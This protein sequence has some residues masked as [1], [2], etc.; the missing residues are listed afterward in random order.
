MLTGPTNAQAAHP[1]LPQGT[2]E[3]EARQEFVASLKFHIATELAGTMKDVYESKLEPQF[4]QRHGHAPRDVR[5]VG[6]VM[7]DQPA[8]RYWSALQRASQEMMWHAAQVSVERDAARINASARAV[9][10]TR[11]S[12]RLNPSLEVPKYL[13]AVDIHCMPGNYHARPAGESDVS[14]GAVYDRGVYM[15][16][17]GRLGRHNEDLGTSVA[18]YVKEAYPEFR[19]QRILDLGCTVGHSTLPY[20]D[21][22]PDAEIHAVD[23]C[24]P[25][26]EYGH[27]RARALGKVVHFSQQNAES[28]DFLDG[29]F[30][31]VVSHILVHE[32][33]NKAI[34]NIMREAHRVLRPGG[35]VAHAETT[36]YRHM[37]PYEAFMLDWDAR[38]NNEP[39]WTA[40]HHLDPEVLAEQTGFGREN[41]FEWSVP[42]ALNEP[43]GDRTRG[44]F[45]AGDFGGSGRWY[46]FGAFRK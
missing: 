17:M 1:L 25:V 6:A 19:P 4:V 20:C 42:S 14:Q 29:S 3:E 33:S 5:E 11:G 28:L 34:R 35:L 23:V 26:L 40:F 32:T 24:G 45:Q 44:R 18:R 46:V 9:P 39:Y 21:V 27:A 15:Y 31:L 43:D 7:K 2:L 30:D 16:A 8:Y 37:K 13:S 41:A 38:N 10:E 22:F 36:L 12:L